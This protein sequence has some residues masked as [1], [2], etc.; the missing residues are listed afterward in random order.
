VVFFV[1]F[2]ILAYSMSIYFIRHGESQANKAGIFAG[3]TDTALTPLGV[4]QAREAGEKLKLEGLQ[5]DT[6]ISSP[7]SRAHDTAIE[8][9]QAIGYPLDG[10]I[11]E[12]LLKERGLGSLEGKVAKDSMP[13]MIAMSEDELIKEGIETIS[14]IMQRAREVLG[15]FEGTEKNILL[16]SHNGLGRGL[17]AV[18]HNIAF[19]DIQKLPNAQVLDLS[20][21]PVLEDK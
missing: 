17:L 13:R 4:S 12:S 14:A 16:V 7:L 10:I 1:C 15:Q 6:I 20:Q 21:P 19:Y 2:D 11:L 9:A 3:Q 18:I 8:I 5:F